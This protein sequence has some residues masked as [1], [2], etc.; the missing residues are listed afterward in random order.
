MNHH[1]ALL[2]PGDPRTRSGGYGYDRRIVAGLRGRDWQVDV[3]TLSARFPMPDASALAA[4]E[5][6]I[7]SLP[8]GT[9][10]VI[11]G[12]AGGAMPE[13]IERHRHRLCWVALVHHPLALE[14]GLSTSQRDASS[15][16]WTIV[17]AAPTGTV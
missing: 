9:Q 16:A 17:I 8:T 12:L 7:A 3:H 5:T 6:Q 10:V 2:L 13:V 4:A 1:L 15:E 11:D 14:T